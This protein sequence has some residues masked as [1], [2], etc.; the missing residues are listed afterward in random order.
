MTFDEL[1]E[2]LEGNPK[3]VAI[4]RR[5]AL[6]EHPSWIACP[7]GERVCASPLFA[8]VDCLDVGCRGATS[9]PYTLFGGDNSCLNCRSTTQMNRTL[10]LSAV[11]LRKVWEKLREVS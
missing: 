9:C 4:L 3:T 5:S 6:H 10:K 1:V 8:C 11:A 2:K 7:G